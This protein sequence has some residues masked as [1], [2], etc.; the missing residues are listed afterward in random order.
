MSKRIFD[1]HL[2]H[3]DLRHTGKGVCFYIF[4]SRRRTAVKWA[5]RLVG[6]EYLL[7]SVSRRPQRV[8]RA[9]HWTLSDIRRREKRNYV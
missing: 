6:N 8:D 9:S 1:V 5:K 2:Q 3:K 7:E 4:A